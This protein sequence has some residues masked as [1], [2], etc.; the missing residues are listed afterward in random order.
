MNDKEKVVA[1]LEGKVICPKCKKEITYLEGYREKRFTL[2]LETLR[3]VFVES[4]EQI[5]MD[6]FRAECPE[7]LDLV[8]EDYDEAEEILR[9]R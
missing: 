7:C 8:T 5:V 1:R 4:N 6:S 9:G 2:E 3:G